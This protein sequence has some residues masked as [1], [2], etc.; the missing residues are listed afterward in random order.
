MVMLVGGFLTDCGQVFTFFILLAVLPCFSVWYSAYCVRHEG[1]SL[2]A[3]LYCAACLTVGY[4]SFGF[5]NWLKNAFYFIWIFTWTLFPSFIYKL[6]LNKKKLRE[7]KKEK[8]KTGIY[9]IYL[10]L[11]MKIIKEHLR[12]Q[13]QNYIIN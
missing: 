10:K 5:S 9:G 2:V 4:L 13:L 12:G 8:E 7:Q 6:T 1:R 3:A 11:P